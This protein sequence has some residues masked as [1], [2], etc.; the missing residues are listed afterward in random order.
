M[1]AQG[2]SNVLANA[3]AIT[4]SGG[5]AHGL[6]G[7]GT[8]NAL[9]N[10]GTI[11]VSGL[12]AHGI[13]SLGTALGP[14]TNSGMITATGPGG[15]GA[16]IGGPA[17]FSNTA[18]GF[19]FSQQA[20]GVIAN[21]GGTISNAGT[22]TGQ[23]AGI[24][25]ANGSANVTNAG[26]ITGLTAPGLLFAGNFDNTLTNTGT[27]V[28]N[29]PPTAGVPLAVL[30]GGGN[31]ILNMQAGAITGH[32]E[33]GAGS[34]TLTLTSGTIQSL[35]QGGD[36]DTATVEGGRIVGAFNDGDFFTMTGGRIGSVDLGVANNVMRMSGGTI[37][38]NVNADQDN[39]LLELSGTGMIG[40][41]VDFGNGNNTISVTG[42]SIG[43]GIITGVG[44]DT[45]NW[46]NAGTI[47][48]AINLGR[49]DDVATLTNLTSAIMAP[50]TLL[51]GDSGT[52]TLT[53]N[54]T[55]ATGVG[56]FTNWEAVNLTNGSRLTLDG[57]LVLGDAGSASPA[58]AVPATLTG[59]LSIDAR[60]TL[61]AGGGVNPA[62]LPSATG[63]LV[64]VNN[65]GTIDQR[66][67]R[68]PRLTA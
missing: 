35:N 39:D 60:S 23:A 68:P 58:P 51:S 57:N 13:T 42:G 1:E 67:G 22:I 15:L 19:I 55:E 43:N 45:F 17:T 9:I 21:G 37:D 28:G 62:I 4:T 18:T 34:D 10:N 47:A 48:S 56:R 11:N 59:A 12:N 5:A 6:L 66:T 8:N 38:G 7:N 16:F 64:T 46:S 2:N 65:T 63:Q 29:G 40:G 27:I 52:D 53:F 41:R 49:G 33:Q 54:N 44:V 3:G 20:S 26:T 24:T 61:F 32:V 36:L 30:F 50:M 14:I 25:N 31:D